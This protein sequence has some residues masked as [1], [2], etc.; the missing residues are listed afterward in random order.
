MPENT[1]HTSEVLHEDQVVT[2]THEEVSHSTAG[3]DSVLASLGINGQLFAFQLLNFAIVAAI[4]W[5]LI[6]KPLT[7]KMEERKKMIDDS[8][9]N[10]Q[11]VETKLQMSEQKYQEKIDEAKMEANKVIEK[12][13]KEAE[14]LKADMRE[15]AKKEIETLINQAKRNIQIEKEDM[16][17]E[18]KKETADLIAVAVEKIIDQKLDAK[19]DRELIEKSISDL[20]TK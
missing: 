10:T 15:K 11:K 12:A 13:Q 7:K 4:L 19:K 3:D 16:V 8:I 20:Q 1:E 6:L 17:E 5:F 18:L 9:E 2:E 14:S